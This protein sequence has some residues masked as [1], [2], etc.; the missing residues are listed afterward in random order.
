MLTEEKKSSIL[1]EAEELHRKQLAIEQE[2]SFRKLCHNQPFTLSHMQIKL[3]KEQQQKEAATPFYLREIPDKPPPPYTP[4]SKSK[5][6]TTP[7]VIPK[8]KEECEQIIEYCVKII[9]K[10]YVCD[11]LDNITISENTL[12][13]IAKDIDKR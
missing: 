13:L 11:N 5:T 4:P 7:S 2:V 6:P 9:H 3:L 10:A 12:S 8:T 1:T